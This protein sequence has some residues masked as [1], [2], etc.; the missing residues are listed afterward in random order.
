MWQM[1]SNLHSEFECV[2]VA[3]AAESKAGWSHAGNTVELE[4]RKIPFSS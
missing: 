4:E 1:Q 2:C 3:Q